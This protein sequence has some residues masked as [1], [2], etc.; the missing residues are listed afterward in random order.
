MGFQTTLNPRQMGH[1]DAAED[2]SLHLQCGDNAERLAIVDPSK[3]HRFPHPMHRRYSQGHRRRGAARSAHGPAQRLHAGSLTAP[4]G[5]G[6][7]RAGSSLI[8]RHALPVD[9]RGMRD[10]EFRLRRGER[11]YQRAC[12]QPRLAFDRSRLILCARQSKFDGAG[13]WRAAWRPL[14]RRR[15]RSA[16]RRHARR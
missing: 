10:L 14:S 13:A 6:G 1:I 12:P 8:G 11:N 9:R 5:A 16:P 7:S 15:H 2:K 3:C 4:S